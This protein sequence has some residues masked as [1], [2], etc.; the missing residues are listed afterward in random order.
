MYKRKVMVDHL[1]ESLPYIMKFRE[2]IFVFKY[3]GSIVNDEENKNAF[4]EDISFLL[5]LGMKVVIVHGGGKKINAR[6][7]EK[8]IEAKFHSGYRITDDETMQEVEMVLSG[9][10]NK[11]LTL[12][13]NNQQIKAV[14]LN[15]KDAGLLRSQK[16]FINNKVDIGNVGDI[17]EINT[18]YINLLL[19]NNYLPIISPIGFDDHGNTYNIN[20]D[21]VAC[22]LAIELNA[23][24]LFLL[25]DIRGIYKDIDEEESFISRLQVSE[26][27][28]LIEEKIIFGGMIPKLKACINSIE[29]GVKSTHI[30]D[31]RVA[32]ATLLEVFTDEGIGTM[33][34]E[35]QQ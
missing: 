15:G 8:G 26:A 10:I 16:K 5:H 6:L 28:Q 32:H 25:S 23:E 1:I 19:D 34:E 21:D 33:I 14:G 20:A 17:V 9:N 35:D 4:I 30:I 24:K 12:K 31:G 29:H 27:K 11:E 3:G 22:K 2:K 18:D 13:F 7:E